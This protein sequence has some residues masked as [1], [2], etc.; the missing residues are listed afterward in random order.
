M[1][2]QLPMDWCRMTLLIFLGE[3]LA[4]LVT[5]D[6]AWLVIL[7]NLLAPTVD[8]VEQH[9]IVPVSSH[10]YLRAVDYFLN[11]N[12]THMHACTLSLP[13]IP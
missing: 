6:L 4:S 9:Q 12:S 7:L 5:K 11:L 3:W 10:Y 1:T 8:G 13:S 2:S